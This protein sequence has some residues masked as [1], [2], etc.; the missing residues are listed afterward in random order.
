MELFTKLFADLLAF[1]YHCFDRIVKCCT[2]LLQHLRSKNLGRLPC[3]KPDRPRLLPYFY[4]Q[5]SAATVLCGAVIAWVDVRANDFCA[6]WTTRADHKSRPQE[7]NAVK[8]ILAF[9]LLTWSALGSVPVAYDQQWARSG[10]CAT[11]LFR[12]AEP[13]KSRPKA[14][15]KGK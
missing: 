7:A 10:F 3:R 12:C 6:A 15:G 1:V 2:R 11:S 14:T 4:H 13:C 9:R 5:S 8:Q